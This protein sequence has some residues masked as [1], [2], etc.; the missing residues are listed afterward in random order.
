MTTA[1]LFPGQGSQTVGMGKALAVAFPAAR[2]VFDEIDAA[3]GEKLSA[4]I[5]DGP[6]DRLTLTENAQ[7]ALMAVSMA[8]LRVLTETKGIK[9]ADRVAFVAGHS[10]GEYSALA[11]VGAISLADTARYICNSS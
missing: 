2:A 7:P 8:A 9:L 1:F 4:I 11:A 5:W 10:L 3:L 6:I